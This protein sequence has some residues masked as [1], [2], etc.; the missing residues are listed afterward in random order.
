VV[1]SLGMIPEWN[2][3]GVCNVSCDTDAFI[4]SIKPL[5]SPSMTDMEGVFSAGVA[6]GPKDIVDTI[7]EA[8]AAAIEAAKYLTKKNAA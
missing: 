5:T 1:L 6:L 3:A 4:K 8:G 7:T 2:P